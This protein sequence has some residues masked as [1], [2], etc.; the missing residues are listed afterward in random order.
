[1]VDLQDDREDRVRRQCERACR[2]AETPQQR[3]FAWVHTEKETGP[4]V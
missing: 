2:A 1:M 4:N 3:E